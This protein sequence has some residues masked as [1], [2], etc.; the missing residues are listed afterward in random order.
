[1]ILRVTTSLYPIISR[2]NQRSRILPKSQKNPMSPM[3]RWFFRGFLLSTDIE[4][5]FQLQY[6]LP[7]DIREAIFSIS[8][9]G[10]ASRM[11][12]ADDMRIHVNISFDKELEVGM[13]YD[14]LCSRLMDLEEIRFRRVLPRFG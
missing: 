12:Y 4:S 3:S 8:G 1:M 2:S 9:I 14:L 11:T 13:G 7:V 10:N 5:V 6:N